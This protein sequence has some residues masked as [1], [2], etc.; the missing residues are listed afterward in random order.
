MGPPAEAA[1]PL[2]LD[3]LNGVRALASLLIVLHHCLWIWGGIVPE[4]VTAAAL[5]ERLWVR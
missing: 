5:R 3:A 1:A 2:K 4:D